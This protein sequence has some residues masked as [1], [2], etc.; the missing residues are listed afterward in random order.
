MTNDLFKGKGNALPEKSPVGAPEQDYRFRLFSILRRAWNFL[1]PKGG[2][3]IEI[4][5]ERKKIKRDG[6]RKETKF[7]FRKG[8]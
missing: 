6:T 4:D 5:L 1:F 3:T 7:R 2:G 8:N